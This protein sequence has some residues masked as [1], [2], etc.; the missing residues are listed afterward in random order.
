[1]HRFHSDVL[2]GEYSEEDLK[3]YWRDAMAAMGGAP[4]SDS[5]DVQC[6]V[7]AA[8]SVPLKQLQMK[9]DET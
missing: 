3:G 7:V 2:W 9:H 5:K 4:K 6:S 8:D 1:M